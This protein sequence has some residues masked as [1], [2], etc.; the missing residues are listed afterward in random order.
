ML[1]SRLDPGWRW[2]ACT[3]G[4]LG[5][6]AAQLQ[7]PAL[8]PFPVYLALV[9]VGAVLLPIV[10]VMLPRARVALAVLALT[11]VG[12]GS[13]AWRAQQR[14]DDRL[15]PSLEG[16]DLIVD[17]VVDAMPQVSPDGTRFQFAVAAARRAG[18]PVTLPQRIS[19]SWYRGWYEDALIAGPQVDLRAG[20]RWQ[21]PVRLR[22]PHGPFNPH[23]HDTELW[24]FERE[25]G[26]SGYVRAAPAGPMPRLLAAQVGRPIERLRQ[27]LRDA[28]VLRVDDARVGGVLAALAVGDQAAIERG[29]WDLFRQ[30]GVAHLMSISGL[31]VTMFAW[32]S[33]LGLGWLWRRSERACLLLPAP[34]ASRWLGLGVAA[35]YALIA[36]WGVPAQRTLL[37]LACA[38]A[39]RS[40]GLRWPWPM[41]LLAA[42]AT[43]TLLDP[44]ALLQAG[45][46]LSFVAV[47]LLLASEPAGGSGGTPRGL[48]ARSS[49]LL[50]SQVI[51]TLGLA[52]LSM[53]FFQ[54]VS[55]VGFLAN[56]VAIPWVTLLV[57]PLSLLGALWPPLWSLA[58]MAMSALVWLLQA[59]AAWPWAVWSAA[60]A[61]GWAVAAGLLAAMVGL[62]PLPWRVRAWALPLAL[63]LLWPVVQRPPPGAFE[64]TAVDIGQGTAVLVRTR[65]YLLVYDTGPAYAR[66][67]D[68]GARIVL[69]LLRARGEQR[70][71]LLMLSHRD[72]DHVGGAASLQSALP[73]AQWSSSLEQSHPLRALA[74]EHRRC[75]AGQSWLWDGVRFDVLHPDAAD[76]ARERKPNALSCVVRVEGADGA[77]A[78][79]TGDIE[80]AQEQAL[81]ERHATR[82]ASQVLIVPHYGSRTSSTEAF[83]DAVQPRVAVVQAAYRSRFGH[84]N[85]EVLSRY[86]ARG[87]EMVRSDRCGAWIWRDGTGTCTRDVQRR[88]WHWSANPAGAD[89]ATALRG[90]DPER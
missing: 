72:S 57:T 69:P 59:M 7:Q 86:R 71:D 49:A 90:G 65:H 28:V 61:P 22:R 27:T 53:V 55:V 64:L 41:T 13:T 25:L 45:F 56:L 3:L 26:A 81:A 19:L 58:G 30:T 37:M 78:L 83:I 12:F 34:L 52:P 60:A 77:S 46:W 4:W 85:A 62:L 17:G 84:P 43:V 73:V 36:G 47:A 33:A 63:P 87:I 42:A 21:L 70:V 29:D 66:D 48:R 32:L 89:V 74:R 1:G 75:D 88:Y 50:R 16:V 15:L 54:Q 24:M 82:L 35:L 6:V 2:S 39:L 51:A 18:E 20:Q 23:G 31:H 40:A 68:A 80:A 11:L 5:G 79:L 76:H 67:G 44:W 10:A 38:V 14:L 8:W 9:V